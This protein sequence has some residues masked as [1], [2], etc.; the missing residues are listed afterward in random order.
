MRDEEKSREELL[1]E[2]KTLRLRLAELQKS[3]AKYRGVVESSGEAICITQDG[4]L[5]FVNTALVKFLGRREEELVSQPIAVFAHPED[6]D[7]LARM[8]SRLINGDHVSPRH[9]FRVVTAGGEV[10]WVESFSSTITWEGRP[11]TL[12]LIREVTKQVHVEE[13]LRRSRDELDLR[14]RE[15]TAAFEST[16]EKLALE[17]NERRHAEEQLRQ[18]EEQ[19]RRMIEN[20]H[21]AFYR[22]DMDGTITFL[23]PSSERVAGYKPEEALGRNIAEFYADPLERQEFLRLIQENG[24]VDGFQARLVKKDGGIVWVSTTARFFRD[25]DGNIAG[26]EGIS[27]DISENKRMEMELIESEQM[28]RLLSEQSLMAVAILQDGVYHYANEAMSTLLD[29]SLDEILSWSKEEFVKVV[30]PEDRSLVLQQARL[31]QQGDP[32][33]ALSYFFRIITKSG[34][35]KWVEIYS[36]TVQFKE[37]S[38]NLLTMLDVTDRKRAEDAL[39]ASE[40]TLRSILQA[41]PIGIVHMTKDRTFGWTNQSLYSML[42]YSEEELVGK[43]PRMLYESEEEFLRVGQALRLG[44]TPQ[45]GGAIETRFKRKDGSVFDVLLNSAAIVP[46]DLSHGLV[47]TAMEISERKKAEEALK[48]SQAM[49]ATVLNSIPQS[50]FWKDRDS[51]F[52][53]CNEVFARTVG[54]TTPDQIVGKTDFELSCPREHAE[55]YRADDQEV[56]KNNRA[57]YHIIEPVQQADGTRLWVDCTKVPLTDENNNVHGVLGVYEDITER[58]RAEHERDLHAQRLEALT[59]LGQMSDA[60]LSKLAAFAM[61][62]AVRLTESSI[63][64][65]AFANEDESILTMHAW[66]QEAMRQCTVKDQPL[67]YPVERTG[68]WG[69]AVRQRR[70]IITNYYSASSPWKKGAPDGH[71]P[72]RRHLNVPIIDDGRVV[73]VVG[74]G[75]KIGPYDENDVRQLTLLMEGTWRIVRRKLAEE[76]LQESEARF[77]TVFQ[78]SPDAL[79]ISRISNG[80]Y[81]DVNTAFCELSGFTKD[82]VIGKSSSDINIWHDSRDRVRLLAEIMERGHVKSLEAQFRCKDGLVKTGLVSANIVNLGGE[83]HMLAI[84]KDVDDRKKA[85][86]A[87]LESEE[88]YRDLFDNASDLIYTLDLE[89]NATSVNE[90]ITKILGYT[91]DEFL[92]LKAMQVLNSDQLRSLQDLETSREKVLDGSFPFEIAVRAKDGRQVWLEINSR[93]IKKEGQVIGV[94]GTARD[95]TPRKEADV[96]RTRLLAAIEQ[97]GESIMVTDSAARIIHVNPAFE[98][99]TGFTKH[100]V[101]GRN[102]GFLQVGKNEDARF[103]GIWET[104]LSGNVWRGRL[105]NKRKD[106]ASYEETATI[107]AVKDEAGK[108]INYVMVG[109]DVTS[110]IML[111]KQLLQAQKMEAVGTL[112]GGIAHDVNNLL[113][114]IL[115]YTDLLLMKKKSGDPDRKKLEVIRNAARDGADLVSRI[116]TFS[117]KADSRTRPLDLNQEIRRAQRLLRRTLPRMIDIKLELAA[118]LKIVDADPSQVEQMLL[119]LAVNA[120]HAMPDGGQLVISTSN[121][122]LSG[123]YCQTHVDIKPGEYVLLA[124]SDTGIGI[125]SKDLDRIFEPFFTTKTSGEGT[126]LGLAMVHGIISQHGGHIRCYSEPGAG[127]SFK[128]YFPVSS[129]ER[130]VDLDV[131]KEMPS[132]GT[133]TILLVEDD[134]RLRR[135]S[136]ELLDMAGY[137]PMVASSGEKALEIYAAHR[138]EISLVIL[139]L[140]MPGMGG[141]RCLEE[142]LRI[143]PDVRILVASGYSADGLTGDEGAGKARGFI[144]KPYDAKDIL[145]AVRKVLEEGCL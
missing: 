40:S 124:V 119:N 6:A 32:S 53:G 134:E 43:G 99:T 125:E 42:G 7:E 65:V 80:T 48:K 69:E 88:R 22:T 46:G 144:S 137:K 108:I 13:S 67:V 102:P 138:S 133:E 110:E 11:A 142:L 77:R 63:G 21:D 61:E 90:A 57:K 130:L 112:A 115:G 37:R 20:L 82:E 18:S 89:G 56:I 58:M 78:T 52:L 28:F 51:V 122:S 92:N 85:E 79:S 104:L 39:Q 5:K 87:L 26:L 62:E 64:Y 131:P 4:I 127:T 100:E 9:I 132:Y 95:I 33:Q 96:E 16:N 68:L 72:I 83:P 73:I 103:R 135:M 126:G 86:M 31:K 106:G 60:P 23:S 35:S 105:T 121:A 29:Y 91:P 41:A 145:K 143:D 45:G 98:E 34:K 27:R 114:A 10:R 24:Y 74:V 81:V 94:H 140:I 50:V 36:R 118:D 66:S 54:L 116:L 75:N 76:A 129:S 19:F 59:Q 123:E 120:Q 71:V 30:H 101:L 107:S 111:Q 25:R 3:E 44:A 15:R 93:L 97:V 1:G 55:G 117:K 38:A 14:M 8:S 47:S 113:Q 17:I 70:P 12:S 128:L 139:D 49:L 84:T 141:K 109:R 136:C 2:V